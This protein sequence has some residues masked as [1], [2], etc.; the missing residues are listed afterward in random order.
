MKT[1][2]L[3]GA[4]LDYWVARAD[5]REVFMSVGRCWADDPIDVYAP[6]TNWAQGGP[7]IEKYGLAV[8]G[9]ND[10]YWYSMPS[11]DEV[12]VGGGAPSDTPL[13]ALC[14]AVVRA[15]FGDEVEDLPG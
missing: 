15:A 12:Y 3:T 1:S 11:S 9:G 2:K 6:S 4:L 13:Q 5:G 10:Q 14:R 7:L 8:V